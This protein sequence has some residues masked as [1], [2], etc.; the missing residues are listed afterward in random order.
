MKFLLIFLLTLY[1]TGCAAERTDDESTESIFPIP[2]TITEEETTT[3]AVQVDV[4]NPP[5]VEEPVVEEPV[6][7]EP[8]VEEPVIRARDLVGPKLLESSVN[9]GE[10]RVDVNL[11]SITFM[12][13]ENIGKSNLKL[14]DNQNVSLKWTGFIRDKQVLL[15]KL[16]GADL[17]KEKV[18]SIIGTV[19]DIEGNASVILITF[20]T[21]IK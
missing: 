8:V 19:E 21:E 7:E 13:N 15:V 1:I 3:P 11:N 14:V 18:Y 4:V 10:I 2:P 5:I 12:F 17:E 20:V 9:A 16:D 6:V